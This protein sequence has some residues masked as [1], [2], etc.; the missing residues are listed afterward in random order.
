[1]TSYGSISAWRQTGPTQTIAAT[2]A[3]ATVTNPF[4]AQ[5]Y[6]IRVSVG[7]NAGVTGLHI[8]VGESPTPVAVIGDAAF[9]VTWVEYILVNPGQKLAAITDAGTAT[10]HVTELS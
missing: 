7:L 2:N 9:P 4:G 5:T 10:V 6:A 8:R 3:S 1:M